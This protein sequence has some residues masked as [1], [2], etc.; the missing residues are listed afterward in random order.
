MVNPCKLDQRCE[1]LGN[2]AYKCFDLETT[3][4]ASISEQTGNFSSNS[5]TSVKKNGVNPNLN[6]NKSNYDSSKAKNMY[7]NMKKGCQ[8][9]DQGICGYYATQGFCK[10]NYYLHGKEI[11]EICPKACNMCSS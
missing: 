5:E 6:S 8:D 9:Y 4:V 10:Q 3:T 7:Y 2:I 1:P 11:L